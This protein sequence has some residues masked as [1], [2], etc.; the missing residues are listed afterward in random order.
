MDEGT[1]RVETGTI[2]EIDR[3]EEVLRG[4]GFKRASG[5]TTGQE[6]KI[7]HYMKRNLPKFL[8]PMPTVILTWRE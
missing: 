7:N 2:E 5:G 3:L 8:G 4:K 6:L 1:L